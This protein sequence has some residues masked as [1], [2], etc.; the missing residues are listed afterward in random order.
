MQVNIK[1]FLDQAGIKDSFYPG[2]RLVVPCA[3]TGEYKSHCLVLD[4]RDPSKILLRVKPGMSGKDLEPAKIKK[5]PVSLQTPTYVEIEVINDN[6]DDEDSEEETS[7][8]KSG[9]SSKGQKTKKKE[10]GLMASMNEAFGEALEGKIPELAKIVD[11]MIMGS[12]ISAKAFGDVFNK[13]IKQISHLKISPTDLLA[14]AGQFLKKVKPPSFIEPK[15][16]EQY[17]EDY[18]YNRELNADIGYRLS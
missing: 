18:K 10:D 1:K 11:M 7:K 5:Y 15:A 16:G 3:Q 4:W 14:E 8:G 17:D 6:E 2:K 9:G 13:L 12:Q